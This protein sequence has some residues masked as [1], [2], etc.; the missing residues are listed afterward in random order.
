MLMRTF[1]NIFALKAIYLIL[2]NIVWINL[3]QNETILTQ[4]VA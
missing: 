3:K 4:T 1:F 2:L